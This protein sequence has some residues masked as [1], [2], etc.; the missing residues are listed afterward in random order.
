MSSTDSTLVTGSPF[1]AR[2]PDKGTVLGERWEVRELE[3][4]DALFLTM[5]AV[6]QESDSV[7]LMRL[8]APGLLG[9]KDA[10]R[11]AESLR[12]LVG[13]G[14][15]T[16]NAFRDVDREG[17]TL[18]AVEPYPTGA[19][20]R[21]VLEARRQKGQTFT[22][23]ELVPVVARLEAALAGIPE[24]FFHGDLRP[25]RIFVAPERV[26]LTGG[27]FLAVMP[28]DPL[29]DALQRD[30]PLR[31]QFAPE[32][33]DGLA[34]RPADRWSVAA[35]VWEA[36]TGGAPQPGPRIAPPKLGPLGPVLARY[37]DAD[38]AHRPPT[39]GPL[40]DALASSANVAVPSIAPETLDLESEVTDSESTALAHRPR[41]AMTSDTDE[42]LR[43]PKTEPGI[44]D[45]ARLPALGSD[46]RPLVAAPRPPRDLQGIDP[47]LLEAAEASR[48][49]SDSGTFELDG[50]ELERLDSKTG[51]GRAG[52]ATA[53]PAEKKGKPASADRSSDLDPNLV[54]AA[55]G[56]SLPTASEAKAAAKP[57]DKARPPKASPPGS[58]PRQHDVTQELSTGDLESLGGSKR[59]AA[60]AAPGAKTKSPAPARAALPSPG[61]AP[62]RKPTPGAGVPAPVVA[63]QRISAPPAQPRASAPGP[64][65]ARAPANVAPR[66]PRGTPPPPGRAPSAPAAPPIASAP[67]AADSPFSP[68][69][70]GT[71]PAPAPVRRAPAPGPSGGMIVGV[72]LLLALVILGGALWYRYTEDA[73]ARELR[74]D[75]RLRELRHE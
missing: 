57:A 8:C 61:P 37:L 49:M 53:Q 4:A 26:L 67:V 35:L 23:A 36:L 75:E 48:K 5:R 74:I 73:E 63:P 70:R 65:P 43:G 54:R 11:M 69:A 42:I 34:G 41:G 10:R 2:G 14:G 22:P 46:G 7:V 68:P 59:S 24:P 72:A 1:S 12:R 3:E 9:D 51:A 27:F 16:I 58:T 62:A 18:Y 28:G 17:A 13:K 30:I 25:Q 32:V 50:Q 19:S 15:P 31:R 40:L 64:A 56:G 38:P 21:S 47:A 20:L 66:A 60:S 45:T 33:G 29:V 6:D 39:L 55:L 52:K 44:H 71:Y